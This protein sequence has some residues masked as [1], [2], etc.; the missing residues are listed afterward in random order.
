MTDETPEKATALVV[1]LRAF[2]FGMERLSDVLDR[3]ERSRLARLLADRV[4]DAAGDLAI[5]VVSSAPEVSA[6]ASE[7]G[8]EV[9]DDPG[10]LDAA[11]TT[12]CA[13][14]RARGFAR[15]VVAHADLPHVTSFDPVVRGATRETVVLVPDH[16]DDGT[17]V[18]SLPL[19]VDFRF[20]YGPGSFR[21]HAA[22]VR[23][24]GLELSVLRS[25]ELGFDVDVPADLD[26]LSNSTR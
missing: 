13:W 9:L 7:R 22:E 15:A 24:L 4:A 25:A 3:D 16:R 23:R 21:R 19:V 8:A 1:P 14:A 18:I 12:G 6:W 10:S 5:A 2:D 11:A 26:Q 20:A 17:P